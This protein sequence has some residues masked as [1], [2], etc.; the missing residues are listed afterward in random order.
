MVGWLLWMVAQMPAPSITVDGV[1]S[2]GEDWLLLGVSTTA[3]DPALSLDTLWGY[4]TADTLYVAFQARGN[5]PLDT[6][7]FVIPLDR[8]RVDGIS[9]AYGNCT[10]DPAG[11][12]VLFGNERATVL[13]GWDTLYFAPD[14]ALVLRTFPDPDGGGGVCIG[15]ALRHSG[16]LGWTA[17][18]AAGLWACGFSSGFDTLVVEWK[19][20][21]Q[22]LEIFDVVQAFHLNLYGVVKDQA[23]PSQNSAVDCIPMDVQCGDAASERQDADTL[24]ALVR[25]SRYRRTGEGL[26]ITEVY[27]D[28]PT[29][30][31]EPASEFVEV[32]NTASDTADLSFFIFTDE[33]LSTTGEGRF[34]LPKDVYLPPGAFLVLAS[35]ADSV[36]KY[37]LSD[38][39][40]PLPGIYP[41]P[42]LIAYGGRTFTGTISLA[43]TGDDV[44]LFGGQVSP[45]DTT[46][47]VGVDS[48]WYGNGGDVGSAGAAA[49][50]PSGWSLERKTYGLWSGTPAQDFV[51][52]VP[53]P[54]D[55]PPQFV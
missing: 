28:A 25:L 46:L 13:G 20:A 33:V 3:G 39:A 37:H 51:Q 26:R 4:L 7:V 8:D 41:Y 42:V 40:D 38:P 17:T 12:Q 53:A 54:G 44:H 18:T 19:I 5:F 35:D 6:L 48:V 36:D 10:A 49:T 11:F 24:S 21:M 15:E 16:V 47:L 43:N 31:P 30:E 14:H 1:V 22:D 9:C 55:L 45:Y 23:D 50:V 34:Q 52:A 27:Y 29:G 32:L 2:P